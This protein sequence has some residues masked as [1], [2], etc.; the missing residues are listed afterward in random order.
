MIFLLN[1]FR[2][3]SLQEKEK[4]CQNIFRKTI[5]IFENLF[6]FLKTKLT[7]KINKKKKF[8]LYIHRYTYYVVDIFLDP[9]S[10]ALVPV[11][12]VTPLSLWFL[13]V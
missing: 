8:I 11:F 1:Y 3:S 9:V 4:E 13:Y 6:K 10:Q 12:V 2:P 7:V 5:S